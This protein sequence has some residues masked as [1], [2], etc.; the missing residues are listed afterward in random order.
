MG[1]IGFRIRSQGE[2]D[3]GFG[4]EGLGTHWDSEV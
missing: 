2:W 3:L 1:F 4:I